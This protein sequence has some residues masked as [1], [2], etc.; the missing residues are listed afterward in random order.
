LHMTESHYC[1]TLKNAGSEPIVIRV[2]LDL[3]LNIDHWEII[4]ETIQHDKTGDNTVYWN[5]SVPANGNV[6]LK[7]QLRYIKATE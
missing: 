4:R 3:P 6:Q 7:Y 1:L 2:V 5:V